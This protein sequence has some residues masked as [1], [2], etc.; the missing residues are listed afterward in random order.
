MIPGSYRVSEPTSSSR[1]PPPAIIIIL[2]ITLSAETTEQVV[3]ETMLSTCIQEA[4]VLKFDGIAG[5]I[6]FAVFFSLS[7]KN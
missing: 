6:A 1:S 5:L 7:R 2:T 3:T 4:P